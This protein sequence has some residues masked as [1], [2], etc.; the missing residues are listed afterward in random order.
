MKAED[1]L[2]RHG[3]KATK[4]RLEVIRVFL[5]SG[6]PISHKEIIENSM[7]RLDRVSVYRIVNAFLKKEII[8]NAYSGGRNPLFELTGR[9][10]ANHCHPHFSCR[11][12][13]KTTCLDGVAFYQ[14]G[15]LKKGYI[16]ERQKVLIEGLCPKCR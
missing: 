2:K 16:A 15:Q 5:D 7:L 10:G 3:L 14:K 1:V 11:M 4:S 8:H 9:G 13:G 12:C 6:G